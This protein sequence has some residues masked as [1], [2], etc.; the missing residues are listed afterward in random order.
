M[1]H[2]ILGLEALTIWSPSK[3]GYKLYKALTIWSSSKTGYKLY[4]TSLELE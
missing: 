2:L 4:K 3:T 1:L